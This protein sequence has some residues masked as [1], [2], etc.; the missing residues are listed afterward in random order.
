MKIHRRT[1]LTATAAGA[2]HLLSKRL[3]AEP[4]KPVPFRPV[5]D[6]SADRPDGQIAIIVADW[7]SHCKRWIREEAPLLR[8]HGLT[9]GREETSHVFSISQKEAEKRWPDAHSFFHGRALLKNV[10]AFAPGWL[11][12]IRGGT[13]VLKITKGASIYPSNYEPGY[14]T[15]KQ[16]ARYWKHR[17]GQAANGTPYRRPARN[18]APRPLQESFTRAPVKRRG[19]RWYYKGGDSGQPLRNHIV[20]VHGVRRDLVSGL[21]DEALRIVHSNRH[22]GFPA[23]GSVDSDNPIVY[24]AGEPWD[25]ESVTSLVRY[26]ERKGQP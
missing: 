15:A 20:Q 18:E 16:I 5:M 22:N 19:P 8:E 12:V 13:E 17:I 6:L 26:L 10:F 3:P 24:V 7:C 25:T 23:F 9:F 1:L 14:Y 11:F 2:I 4:Y 21:S